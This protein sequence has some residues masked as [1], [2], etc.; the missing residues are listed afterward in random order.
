MRKIAIIFCLIWCLGTSASAQQKKKVYKVNL[1]IDLPV[2]IVGSALTGYGFKRIEKKT[3][4]TIEEVNSLDFERDVSGFNRA[5]G[6]PRY[7][8]WASTTSDYLFY[9]AMPLGLG[10]A[11]DENIR[12]DIWTVLLMYWETLAITGSI[13]SHTA[14]S[15]VKYRPL[16]YPGSGAPIEERVED[17]AKNSFPG[18][19][20]TITAA[21]TF[22]IAKVLQDYYPDN[23]RLHLISYSAAGALTFTNVYLR[24]RAGKHFAS[25]LMVGLAY[26]IPLGILIPQIHKIS[27]NNDR[28]SIF[29]G[30]NGMT[31][32][33]T[34]E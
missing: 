16:A 21:S 18:G 28:V 27:E 22:F 17:G 19:H 4:S 11:L 31:L 20:P 10:L 8:E 25:D 6:G 30:P 32:S 1:K 24:H 5:F 7:S 33:Y 26:S 12:D 23:K 2:V 15:V 3:R 29:S 34:I 14:A 13:Y 9:G